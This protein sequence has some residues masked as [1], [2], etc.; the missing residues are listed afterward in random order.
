MM[1]ETEWSTICC[2]QQEIKLQ[3]FM[4]WEGHTRWFESDAMSHNDE[5][6]YI[7]GALPDG[8]G[9]PAG[10]HEMAA[11]DSVTL[12]CSDSIL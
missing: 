10:A 3:I 2:C 9:Q 5:L 6:K 1:M 8:R 4:E 12:E 7:D 11:A